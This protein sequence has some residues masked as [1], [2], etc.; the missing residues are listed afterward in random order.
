MIP[1]NPQCLALRITEPGLDLVH[2]HPRVVVLI[3]SYAL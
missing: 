3:P 2:P 1:K